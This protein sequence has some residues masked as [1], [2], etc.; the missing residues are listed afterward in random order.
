M[1]PPNETN[2]A[3]DLARYPLGG[4]DEA[5]VAS[6]IAESRHR[7]DA[8]QYC[9]MAGFIRKDAL[10]DMTREV[11][12]LLDRAHRAQSWR[13][14]YLQR[15][16]DPAFSADH[17]RNLFNYASYWMIAADLFPESSRLKALYYWEPFQRVIAAIVGEPR[18]Y[19]NEDAMQPVNVICY[20]NGDQSA[21]HYDSTNAF[22]ITLMLQ[23]AEEGGVFELAPNTRSAVDDEDI[24]YMTEI[25]TG[26]SARALSVARGPGE[27]TIFR[28]CNSL[29]RVSP[30][31]GNQ[32]RMMAVFVYETE[33][34][35]T[36]DPEV[37]KTVY[38]R[39]GAVE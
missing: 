4:D 33:P 31:K 24:P 6:V 22:T 23:A 36:G 9:S 25:L 3:I 8:Q 21:W 37:N 5:A 14:C 26:G 2:L 38:G 18:L 29:H 35:V 27:L 34:G 10:A 32:R 20:G 12:S 28:G 13:N 15:E 1:A 11:A 17:P 19:P 39:S 30:V 7:L 16:K